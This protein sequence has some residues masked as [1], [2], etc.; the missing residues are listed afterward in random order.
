MNS[1]V[2]HAFI[3]RVYC[4]HHQCVCVY[5]DHSIPDVISYVAGA[6][7]IPAR[8]DPAICT[9]SSPWFIA[10]KVESNLQQSKN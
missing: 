9:R 1:S 8:S 10:R 7:K 5:N 4:R 2:I 6:Y 3:V